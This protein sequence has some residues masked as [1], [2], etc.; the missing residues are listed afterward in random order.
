MLTEPMSFFFFTTN[1]QALTV[2]SLS[3]VLPCCVLQLL[4][5]GSVDGAAF[6]AAGKAEIAFN[7]A[8]AAACESGSWW[9]HRQ[10][11]L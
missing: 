2:L 5:G 4:S 7:W 9:Q 10:K 6:L 8:G 11:L 1:S 3:A